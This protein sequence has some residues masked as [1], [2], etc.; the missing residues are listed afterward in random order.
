M[1]KRDRKILKSE[2]ITLNNNIYTFSYKVKE[3]DRG[4]LDFQ[5]A[6]VKFNTEMRHIDYVNIPYNNFDLDVVLHT[7]RDKILPGGTETWSLTVKD[8]KGKP[9]ETSMIATMYDA[10]LDVFKPLSWHFNTKPSMNSSSFIMS[11]KSFNTNH[12]AQYYYISHIYYDEKPLFSSRQL[13]NN[14]AD[15]RY[16]DKKLL[17]ASANY[18]YEEEVEDGAFYESDDEEQPSRQDNPQFKIRKDF[19]ETAFF[20]PNL[21]TDKN[22]GCTFTFTMPDVLT[23]WN[24]RLLAYTKDLKVGNFEKTIVTQQPFMIMADMPRF[25]YDEDTLWLVANVINLSDEAVKP[26]A[27]LEV[28]DDSDNLVNLIVSEQNIDM[29]PI[30][31]GQSRS[32]RWKVAMKKDLNIL[33]FRF[34]AITDGFSD[35]EQH[36]MPILSTEVY[37]TQTYA[38]TANAHSVKEYDFDIDREGERNHRITL[39]FNENPIWTA[40]HAMPYL[41]EGD[42]KYAVTAFYRFFVN[43]MAKQIMESHPEI[44]E[45]IESTYKNDTL[46]E[47]QKYEDLKAIILQET[48]WVMEAEHEARQ[49][50]SIVK[51]FNTESVN[52]NI[53][54]AYKL[55]ADKQTPNG[56]WSWIDGTQKVCDSESK[57]F[58][59]VQSMFSL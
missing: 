41:D 17:S 32:V 21:R 53:A 51:L 6:T 49:R 9:V 5:V 43:T 42:E 15:L 46:S 22:G 25:A 13:I 10:A 1:V 23:R 59:A 36:E 14:M 7:E 11:D 45:K 24:L 48:P 28:F 12:A 47:L 33:K 8:Y 40:I 20:F 50:A 16:L 3:E 30:P 4:N 58:S 27:K 31:A 57:L 56:G 54:S 34:S 19:N 26:S 55:L 2:R 52:K 29:E 35:A 38:L 37:L 18:Y 39:Q 44:A